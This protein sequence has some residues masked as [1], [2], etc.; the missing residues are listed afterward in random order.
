MRS[1]S[2]LILSCLLPDRVL[3]SDKLAILQYI[4]PSRLGGAEEY[5]LRLI[6]SLRAS[7]H[8]VIVVTKRDTPLRYEIEKC[9]VELHAWHTHGKIDPV[10]LSRLCRLIRRKRVDVIN[11]H[12]TTASLLGAMAGRMTGVPVIAHVHAADS[13]T[14]FQFAHY[15]VAVAKG[16]EQHLIDQD[17]PAEKI[18]LL[19][20]GV[21]LERYAHPL[22][23]VEAKARLN[24]PSEARTVGIVGSLIDRKG[25]RFLLQALKQIEPQTGPVHAVFA[26]EG[27]LEENLREMAASLGMSERVHFLG[28]RR[29][30]IEVVSALD[31]FTLPSLKE[32]L[33]IAVMEAMALRRP[34]IATAIAGMP[35][36]V[37][38]GETGLL[39]PPGDVEAL[40]QA[41]LRLLNDPQFAKRLANNGRQLLEQHFD[42][43]DCLAA[44]ERFYHQVVAEWRQ[45]RE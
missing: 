35:E 34:V 15:L 8:R 26:G 29:D 43:R 27:V 16:V 1:I 33:S 31:V 20:Y 45:G 11:T 30:V 22:P 41:L 44:V 37:H 3:M 36:V 42:Q 7:G 19:Y 24:L 38:D 21:D 18:H 17:V 12:L 14:F 13:K 28:F 10:T 39:I 40:V 25:H 9:D 4:T 6:K 23:V 32:G 5:F 2:K